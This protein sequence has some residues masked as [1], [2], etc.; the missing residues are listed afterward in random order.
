MQTIESTIIH[1]NVPHEV[2]QKTMN[3]FDVFYSL[4]RPNEFMIDAVGFT[5]TDLAAL[6]LL[7][8]MNC[9]HM[10][11]CFILVQCITD[12]PRYH[13]TQLE[14]LRCTLHQYIEKITDEHAI[15]SGYEYQIG[16]LLS[17]INNFI[18]ALPKATLLTIVQERL[19]ECS[20]NFDIAELTEQ[21][22]QLPESE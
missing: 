8:G 11:G 9:D 14:H 22:N 13:D 21:I 2:F 10:A 6:E 4:S 16:D 12:S 15:E 3:H 19:S 18:E 1:I 7:F 5:P 17:I 20:I